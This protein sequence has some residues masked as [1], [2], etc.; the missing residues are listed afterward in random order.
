[1][2]ILIL[3]ILVSLPLHASFIPLDQSSLFISNSEYTSYSSQVECEKLS[4]NEC[5]K[6]KGIDPNYSEL[7]EE[8]V[9]GDPI[10]SPKLN[11][12]ECG[13]DQCK[14]LELSGHCKDFPDYQFFYAKTSIGLGYEAYCAKVTGYEQVNTGKHILVESAVKKAAYEKS[15]KDAQDAELAAKLK[16]I[17][18]KAQAKQDIGQATTIALLKA[19]VLKYLNTLE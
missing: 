16:K 2:K 18:D 15:L 14:E 1:M 4:M 8:I 12:I 17:Q 6:I 5:L 7:K 13:E 19:A 9:N 11:I 3:I 10:Y